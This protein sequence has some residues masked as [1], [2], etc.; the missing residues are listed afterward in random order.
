MVEKSWSRF[1]SGH[2]FCSADFITFIFLNFWSR[3][4][5]S[6]VSIYPSIFRMMTPT[7]PDYILFIHLSFP[8]IIFPYHHH[9]SI[10]LSSIYHLSIYHLWYILLSEAHQFRLLSFRSSCKFLFWSLWYIQSLEYE[11][12]E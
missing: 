6:I 8:L 5:L 9:P 1:Q 4:L 12:N 7:P 11:E 2:W 3:C 10:Y